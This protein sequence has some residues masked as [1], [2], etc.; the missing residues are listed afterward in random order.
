MPV[1]LPYCQVNNILLKQIY[2]KNVHRNILTEIICSKTFRSVV[3]SIRF[4]ILSRFFARFRRFSGIRNMD[5]MVGR[6]VAVS[7]LECR[8]TALREKRRPSDRTGMR[9]TIGGPG[10]DGAPRDQARCRRLIQRDSSPAHMTSE[11]PPTMIA[12]S[13]SVI[14]TVRNTSPPHVTIAICPTR[15]SNSTP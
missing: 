2:K 6:C 11:V 10:K 15:I 12:Q 1:F 3:L 13:R 8:R 5:K 4:M 14:G 7:F 9:V